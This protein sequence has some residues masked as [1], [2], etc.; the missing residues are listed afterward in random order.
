MCRLRCI[1]DFDMALVPGQR[2]DHGLS[3]PEEVHPVARSMIDTNLRHPFTRRPHASG[4]A[5][6]RRF[7]YLVRTLRTAFEGHVDV[8][9]HM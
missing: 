6:R 8:L 2:D 1:A 4:I 5:P 3:S 7:G 9:G